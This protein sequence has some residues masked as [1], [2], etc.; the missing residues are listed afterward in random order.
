MHNEAIF[1][2]NTAISNASFTEISDNVI[3]GE[4]IRE[5]FLGISSINVEGNWILCEH[6]DGEDVV[7]CNVRVDDVLYENIPFNFIIGKKGVSRVA[8]NKTTLTNPKLFVVEVKE[9][10]TPCMVESVSVLEDDTQLREIQNRLNKKNKIISDLK[11]EIHVAKQTAQHQKIVEE[12]T[13]DL[14]IHKKIDQGIEEYKQKLFESFFALSE[15]QAQLKDIV[16]KS[17]I[18]ELKGI[19]DRKYI[20]EVSQIR[21]TSVKEVR[22]QVNDFLNKL[23]RK[24]NSQSNHSFNEIQETI[25]S[26]LKSDMFLVSEELQSRF[27]KQVDASKQK[28]YEKLESHKNSV[29][30]EIF[31]LFENFETLNRI[32]TDKKIDKKIVETKNTIVNK[33]IEDIENSNSLLKQEFQQN[34]N[35]L[36]Q[37]I[38]KKRTEQIKFDSNELVAEAARLLVEEDGKTSGKLK[39]FKDQLLKELEK[40]AS[41]YTEQANKRMMRYAEMMSGGGS[42]AKQFAA[43]GTMEGDLNVTGKLLSGGRDLSSAFAD[44]NNGGTLNL[45]I[46][47]WNS[48]YN[49]VLTLSAQWSTGGSDQNIAY[50]DVNESLSIDRGNTTSLS[51]LSYR[52]IQDL[53]ATTLE[54]FTN[55]FAGD[56]QRGYTVTLAN[57]KVYTFA[58]TN[59]N[60]PN[61]YLEINS[62]PIT[63]IYTEALLTD[64]EI[65]VDTFKLDDFKSAKYNLQIETNFSN[66]IYYSEINVVGA[67]D[68]AVASEY[69]QIFTSPLI[70]GYDAFI[71]LNQLRL[72]VYYNTDPAPGRKLIIKGHRTNF[73]KI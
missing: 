62:N 52:N 26:T 3:I 7:K 43:G 49:T 53:D 64:S 13:I 68:N 6:V 65:V 56:I 73:Y 33:Y 17:T 57:G 63:P 14:H 22:E 10:E 2:N 66:E 55:T 16:I 29:K 59:K 23:A 4:G 18:K 69:G 51:A 58:G 50:N 70:V 38:N 44:I 34:F 67:V 8:I 47:N 21:D 27:N 36:D 54:D 71:S 42:V 30:T 35:L 11:Q 61:H 25:N 24:L 72:V 28:L 12:Q 45:P 9:E 41:T 37:K 19:F 60:N 48:T 40:A 31:N 20:K 32:E 5:E 15:E 46:D 1:I 39:K